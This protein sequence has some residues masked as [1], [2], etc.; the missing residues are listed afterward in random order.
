MMEIVWVDVDKCHPNDFNPNV[1]N[2]EKFEA[3]CDFMRTHSAEEVDPIWVRHDGADGFEIVDGEHRW[4]AA[5]T[6]GWKRLRAFVLDMDRDDA[7]AF[8]VRKN[9]ERGQLDAIKFGKI[10]Y[11]EHKAGATL[12]ELAKK[13]GYADI[14]SIEYYLTI[15]KN[16][17]KILK[18]VGTAVPTAITYGKARKILR[19]LKRR[20][21]GMVEGNR[22]DA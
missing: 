9:R 2:P 1:M 5:K 6:V 3:L 11:E 18:A 15:Y 4:R 16:R 8:N 17:D 7:K 14:R 10:L 19:E 22:I 13:Y 12:E 20:K 21:N